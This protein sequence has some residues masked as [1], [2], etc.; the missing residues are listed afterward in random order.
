[1]ISQ[2]TGAQSTASNSLLDTFVVLI[3]H[4]YENGHVHPCPFRHLTSVLIR[5]V[6][7][8]R[9]QTVHGS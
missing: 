7:T 8:V 3:M 9:H 2:Q 6:T 5:G 4:S 1:M